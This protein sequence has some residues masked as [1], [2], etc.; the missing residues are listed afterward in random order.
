M[1]PSFARKKNDRLKRG[2]YAERIW[3]KFQ[4]NRKGNESR[5]FIHETDKKLTDEKKER[6]RRGNSAK[7]QKKNKK[8]N[9]KGKFLKIAIFA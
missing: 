7:E 1:R 3:P 5:R 6:E 4:K 8:K 9:K 2:K